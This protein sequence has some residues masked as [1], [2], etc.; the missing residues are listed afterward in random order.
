MVSMDK[1]EILEKYFPK[2][3]A[4]HDV[5][6]PTI[7]A[8]I[9]GEKVLCLMPTGGG[10]SLIYQVAGLSLGKATLVISPLVALMS[11]QC[12]QLTGVGLAL[13]STPLPCAPDLREAQIPS[14]L[15]CCQSG[16]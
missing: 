10:K 9:D 11:Q 2:I 4:F 14:S 7:D 8:L 12:K 15:Y 5:Q 3:E 1:K 6:E 16:C 13:P